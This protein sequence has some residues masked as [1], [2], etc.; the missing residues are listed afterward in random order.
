MN[1]G[2]KFLKAAENWAIKDDFK[3]ANDKICEFED[4]F[5][6]R[7]DFH[8]SMFNDQR[9][10]NMQQWNKI[11]RIDKFL[12]GEEYKEKELAASQEEK[13]NKDLKIKFNSLL[14]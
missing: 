5:R 11:T 4:E 13:K 6:R 10:V 2:E 8:S 1:K 12:V 3:I 14:L 9:A 7:L